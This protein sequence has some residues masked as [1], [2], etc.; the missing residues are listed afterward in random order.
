MNKP[1]EAP[2]L[3]S[4]TQPVSSETG[5]GQEM[6]AGLGKIGLTKLLDKLR[7]GSNHPVTEEIIESPLGQNA[8]L[9]TYIV[10]LDD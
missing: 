4:P 8:A 5:A 7:V 3:P 1:G 9:A 6:A 2:L 10:Q